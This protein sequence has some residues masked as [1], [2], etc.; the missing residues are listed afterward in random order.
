MFN[1]VTHARSRRGR[2]VR[3]SHFVRQGPVRGAARGT[4]RVPARA[5]AAALVAAGVSVSG[6]M[7][8]GAV[9]AAATR[10]APHPGVP[11]LYAQT[12]TVTRLANA[13]P[14]SLRGAITRANLGLPGRATLIHRDD[15]VIAGMG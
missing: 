7:C 4:M 1:I 3:K 11:P 12:F 10:P 6:V 15:M 13:G 9:A 2:I 14:G 8:G 5:T